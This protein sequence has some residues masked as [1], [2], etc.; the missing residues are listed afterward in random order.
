MSQIPFFYPYNMQN[1]SPFP[2][3]FPQPS[4]SEILNIPNSKENLKEK[5]ARKN[6]NSVDESKNIQDLRAKDKKG[7]NDQNE[8]LREGWGKL[9]HI[10]NTA[11]MSEE[12]KEDF[13]TLSEKDH[14]NQIFI[15]KDD[16]SGQEFLYSRVIT[17]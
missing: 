17:F 3:F 14:K 8:D 16:E 1:P 7:H 12:S 15:Y 9:G 13:K 2:Y 6:K 5:V 10:E 11:L 4:Q